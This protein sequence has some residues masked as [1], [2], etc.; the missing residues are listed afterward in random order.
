MPYEGLLRVGLILRGPGIPK[1]KIIDDPVS[2][3]DLGAT[4]MDYAGA[5]ALQ[6]QHGQSLRPLVEGRGS[7]SFARS[8]W[9]LHP[10]RAGVAL[11]LRTVRTKTHKLTVDLRS[12]DGEL[13]D[14]ASDPYERHNRFADVSFAALR[15]DLMNM[16]RSRPDDA[17]ALREPV[18]MAWNHDSREHARDP[19]GRASGARHGLRRTPLR[20]DTQSGSPRRT[21]HDV[22]QC[23]DAVADLRS[24]PRRIRDRPIRQPLPLL[25]QFIRL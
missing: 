25:G 22:H 10:Q 2:T 19:V 6:T 17:G 21:R 11:S 13:Y 4:F 15:T 9:E 3:L 12:G 7:R 24:G 14:L 8:E 20:L 5:A 23:G 1:G 16:I 18:G